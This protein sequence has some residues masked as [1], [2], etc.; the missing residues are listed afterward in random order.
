M[1]SRVASL[2][3]KIDGIANLLASGQQTS[4]PPLPPGHHVAYDT[5]HSSL[6]T[7]DSLGHSPQ[8]QLP[9]R[10]QSLPQPSPQ[11][12]GHHLQEQPRQMPTPPTPGYNLSWEQA[13]IALNE[14]KISYMPNFPFVV[15]EPEVTAQ[16]LFHE[17]PFLFRVVLLVATRMPL[18]KKR[19]MKRNV[20][21]Y[22]GQHLLVNEE[23]SLDLLQGL[24]VFI[25]W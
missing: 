3:Q 9:H 7:P 6:P 21:A 8:Y 20:T 2:E 5:G 12:Y 16:E 14:Y 10:V 23:R 22:L 13:E 11:H 1:H 25:A 4:P 24:L 18:E 19:G 17:K 15:I